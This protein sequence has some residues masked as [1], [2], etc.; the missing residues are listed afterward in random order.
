MTSSAIID[1][2]GY[3]LLAT[4]SY[5]ATNDYNTTIIIIIIIII[6]YK[7]LFFIFSLFINYFAFCFISLYYLKLTFVYE[8]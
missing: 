1:R 6:P 2:N 5:V 8:Y 7:F 4:L 3:S